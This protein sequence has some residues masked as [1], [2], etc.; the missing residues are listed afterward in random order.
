MK[1]E[2]LKV[3]IIGCGTIAKRHFA[4]IRKL[5]PATEIIIRTR[6]DIKK[7]D[8]PGTAQFTASITE[9]AELRPNVVI[10]ASPASEH[11]NQIHHLARN[12]DL[13]IIE[14]PIAANVSD[15]K[16]INRVASKTR[17]DIRIA[18]NLRY[19][20]GLPRLKDCL[21]S[22]ILGKIQTFNITV[23]QDLKLWRPHRKFK[24]S[25][26]AQASKGGGVLR[27]LSHELD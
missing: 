25:V 21:S 3:G 24:D 7:I 15:A 22:R 23:G 11:A 20:A 8:L 4:E 17:C 1:S 16:K 6:Q 5:R 9:V 18:Y 27:E 12:T 14:K 2:P 13:L 19:L 26:S 10:I